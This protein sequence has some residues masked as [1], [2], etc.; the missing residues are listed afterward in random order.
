MRFFLFEMLH[1]IVHLFLPIIDR[2]HKL[3]GDK[4]HDW[5]ANKAFSEKR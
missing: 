2:V 3:F 5:T 4:L 1:G